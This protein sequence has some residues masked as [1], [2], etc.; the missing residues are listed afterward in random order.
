MNRRFNFTGRKRIA[1]EHVNITVK[2]GGSD[3]IATFDAE[4][5]F[6]DLELPPNAPVMIEAFRGSNINRYAWGTVGQLTP[7]DDRSLINMQD[8]PSFRIKVVAPDRSGILLAMASRITPHR[9][10]RRG[11]LV[12]LNTSIDLGKEVWR[13]DF[14]DGNPTL[15]VNASIE[16][17]GKAASSDRAFQSLV[18]PEVLRAMLTQA[19]IVDEA[20]PDDDGGDWLGLMT[21]VRGFHNEPLPPRLT[22]VGENDDRRS[23]DAVRWINDAVR[24]FTQKNFPASDFY[25]GTLQER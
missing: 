18:F 6:D 5:E 25:A 17:I 4:F 21:F 10:E 15:Y 1:L 20:D 11:S 2:D 16:G 22:V 3:G 8:N 7:P 24:A 14:G 19:V 13:L 23:E 12:W 9:E